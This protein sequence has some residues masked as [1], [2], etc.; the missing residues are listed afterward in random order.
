MYLRG[1]HTLSGAFLVVAMG[2]RR[3]EGQVFEAINLNVSWVTSPIVMA[4][5]LKGA[6][7]CL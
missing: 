1:V 2:Q 4:A 6:L 7:L 3:C 5:R